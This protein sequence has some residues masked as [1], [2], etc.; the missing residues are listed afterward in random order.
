MKLFKTISSNFEPSQPFLQW[1]GDVRGIIAA[2]RAR[3]AAA[4]ERP[5]RWRWVR[6]VIVGATLNPKA[7]P[8][9]EVAA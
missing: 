4:R 1:D 9:L 6:R 7:R 5:L 8:A 2:M 3:D